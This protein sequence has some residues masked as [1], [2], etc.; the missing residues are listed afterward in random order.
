MFSPVVFKSLNLEC[1]DLLG[2][3]FSPE[4]AIFL[5]VGSENVADVIYAFEISST[6]V[7]DSR[8]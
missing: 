4:V 7:W 1:Q 5:D 6:S 8:Q 3:L 2:C